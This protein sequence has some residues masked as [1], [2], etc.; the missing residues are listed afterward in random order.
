MLTEDLLRL[1]H[2]IGAAVLFG[3]GAGIAFFMVMA[4]RTRDARLIAHVAGT[5]VV[6]D[7]VF[8]AT[9]VVIQPITGYLLATRI[10]WSLSEG[11][12][13]LSLILYVVTGLFWLPV[14]WVQ[15]RLRN[16]ARLAAAEDTPL[17]AAF[18]RLYAIWFACGFPAF[19]AVI[20]IFWLML[21]KPQFQLF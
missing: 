9:A 10:G 17:P 11:W 6:A 13:A 20:G 8:T 19:F 18:D 2:V 5:V 7:T 1:A 21:A 12:I 15:I 4:R 3:T 14:V 16:L